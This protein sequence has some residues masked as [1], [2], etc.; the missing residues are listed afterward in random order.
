[1]GRP[2]ATTSP[3]LDSFYDLP[4]GYPSWSAAPNA[5]TVTTNTTTRTWP[6]SMNIAPSVIRFAMVYSTVWNQDMLGIVV[7]PYITIHNPYDCAIEFEGI[8]M[9]SNDQSMTYYFEFEVGGNSANDFGSFRYNIGDV[10]L[11]QSYTDGRELSFRAVAGPTGSSARKPKVLRLEPG[12][13]RIVSPTAGNPQSTTQATRRSNLNGNSPVAVPG[14]LV[15]EQQSRMFFPMQTYVGMKRVLAYTP[16]P[17]TG[18][19]KV[20][21][22]QDFTDEE[23]I[24]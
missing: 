12:E 14:D 13:I 22:C 4:T 10:C 1:M 8:A 17:V 23:I 21:F 19:P 20:T 11:S 7:D 3:K 9:V 5:S 6:T 15:F 16:D 18:Q 2:S 24:R